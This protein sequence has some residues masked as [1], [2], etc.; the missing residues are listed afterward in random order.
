M[1]GASGLR[2]WRHE[3]NVTQAKLAELVRERGVEKRI[4]LGCTDQLVGK[5]ERGE[6]Q[7][8][9][10]E[11]RQ[12][13]QEVTGLTPKE[14]GFVPPAEEPPL[15]AEGRADPL[16]ARPVSLP[17][18]AGEHGDQKGPVER[19]T[20]LTGVNGYRSVDPGRIAQAA[21]ESLN[22][23]SFADATNVAD[24]TI[25]E[26]HED[27]AYIALSYVHSPPRSTVFGVVTY[28]RPRVR[29]PGRPTV[30]TA[31]PRFVPDR[32]AGL[33]SAREREHGL[34]PVP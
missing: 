5:W 9:T 22:F 29:S 10:P 7:W 3:H 2:R 25:E 18:V 31:E 34:W 28:P 32:R 14:L 27:V 6:I 33:R 20:L 13:L 16:T 11:Y 21:E 12:V 26:L 23:L 24:E 1:T 17:T 4:N 19:R 30:S 8:P 15:Q